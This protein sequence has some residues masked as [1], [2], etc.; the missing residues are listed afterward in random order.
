MREKKQRYKKREDEGKD[1]TDFTEEK[2]LSEGN[3]NSEMKKKGTMMKKKVQ[4]LQN[5]RNI[6]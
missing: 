3:G 6:I 2:T 5:K 1:G 4:C